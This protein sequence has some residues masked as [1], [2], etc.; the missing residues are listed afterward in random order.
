MYTYN[1]MSDSI[2]NH[3]PITSL[4]TCHCVQALNRLLARP[5]GRTPHDLRA[6]HSQARRATLHVERRPLNPHRFAAKS[7]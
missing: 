4:V 5:S 3:K 1:D 6:R 2:S 7:Y